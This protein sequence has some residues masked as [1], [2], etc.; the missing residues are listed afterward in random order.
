MQ[1][2]LADFVREIRSEKSSILLD[3]RDDQWDGKWEY[4][5]SFVFH[6]LFK[7]TTELPCSNYSYYCIKV[8]HKFRSDFM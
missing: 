7:F 1:I 3:R 4:F 6:E 8:V 2:S 5:I